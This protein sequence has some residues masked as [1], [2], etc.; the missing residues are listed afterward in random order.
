M[1]GKYHMGVIISSILGVVRVKSGI[2][3]KAL[4]DIDPFGLFVGDLIC[5][6]Y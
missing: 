4:G 5:L 6:R 2:Y 3:I 1:N